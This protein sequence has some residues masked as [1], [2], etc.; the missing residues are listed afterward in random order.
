MGV[1]GQTAAFDGSDPEPDSHRE[2][3]MRVDEEKN[4]L[5]F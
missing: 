2:V 3:V 1:N 5:P 4:C